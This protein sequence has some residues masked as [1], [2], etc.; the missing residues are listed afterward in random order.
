MEKDP[1]V[2]DTAHHFLRLFDKGFVKF[3]E[4][5]NE[6]EIATISETRSARDFMLWGRGG[7]VYL[8]VKLS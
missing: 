7:D 4:T 2:W 8:T 1:V 6:A 5:E 3:E